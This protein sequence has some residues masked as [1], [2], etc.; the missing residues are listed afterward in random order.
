MVK[1]IAQPHWNLQLVQN[2][3]KFD[4]IVMVFFGGVRDTPEIEIYSKMTL[5]YQANNPT[6][7]FLFTDNENIMKEYKIRGQKIAM[8]KDGKTT[9]FTYDISIENFHTF[10]KETT[11]FKWNKSRNPIIHE[12]VPYT[13]FTKDDIEED[14]MYTNE[15]RTKMLVQNYGIDEYTKAVRK[16]VFKYKKPVMVVFSSLGEES[17]LMKMEVAEV[18]K[19]IGDKIMIRLYNTINGEFD[20]DL[21]KKIGLETRDFPLVLILVP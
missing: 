20:R 11:G 1:G 8:K 18:A 4:P 14:W 6:I 5:A 10:I 15:D 19:T 3:L 21:L 9:W 2:Y 7:V 17:Q 12:D 16:N 13:P